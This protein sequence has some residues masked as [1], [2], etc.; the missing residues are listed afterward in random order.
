MTAMTLPQ[1]SIQVVNF[2]PEPP[3]EWV[4]LSNHAQAADRAGVDR[5]AVSDHVA[6]GDDLDD[7]GDPSKGGTAGGRQP[8]GPD[9]AWLEPLTTLTWL[10]ART[11]RIRLQT[12]ILLA[13]LRRP[14]VLAK[15]A[16][17][18]DVL[19]NGRLDLGVGVGWQAAEYEAAGLDFAN[20]GRL[21]D[22]SLEVCRALWAGEPASYTSEELA[23]GDV[24]SM[25]SPAHA[26]GVP[27]WIS[28]T[29][30]RR[31]ARRLATFG[32]GWIPWGPDRADVVGGIERM[33]ILQED[34]GLGAPP[35]EVQ[36]T[37]PV[38]R[39]DDGTVDL[40]R[41]MEGVAPLV[42]AGV[43]DCRIAFPLP[44][45]RSAAEDA[46]AQV[47]TAFHAVTGRSGDGTSL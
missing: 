37:L 34:L 2:A 14:V 3:G 15:T 39:C 26:L 21:L 18:L 11:D 40:D 17:T 38:I 42:D 41:T 19:S 31:T 27:I 47:V 32:S 9:G 4:R 36:G 24:Q 5:L 7:Y 16:A 25:P 10:A 12:G 44:A 46:L 6:F 35:F 43:T 8:T 1:L 13:A 28:G 20:R 33:R 29:V 30:N 22:H 45:D 23:F